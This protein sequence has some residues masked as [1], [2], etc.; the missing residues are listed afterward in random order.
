MVG[1]GNRSKCVIL[2]I[3]KLFDVETASKYLIEVIRHQ[4]PSKSGSFFAWDGSEIPW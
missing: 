4:E 1:D 2:P 3:R